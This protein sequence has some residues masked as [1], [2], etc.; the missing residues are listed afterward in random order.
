M[1]QKIAD[2]IQTE[3]GGFGVLVQIVRF[4]FTS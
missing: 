4:V 1:P 3:M 2:K